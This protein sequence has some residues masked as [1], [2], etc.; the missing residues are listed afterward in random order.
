MYCSITSTVKAND[1][2]LVGLKLNGPVLLNFCPVL[3]SLCL[4]GK[5]IY[6]TGLELK[7]RLLNIFHSHS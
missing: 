5:Q 2:L 7:L 6:L 3:Y 1:V 4:V